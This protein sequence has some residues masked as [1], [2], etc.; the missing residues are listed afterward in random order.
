MVLRLEHVEHVGAEGLRAPHHVGADRIRLPGHGKV[1]RGPFHHHPGLEQ[2]VDELRRRG[3]VGLV[4]WEDVPARIAQ[5]GIEQLLIVLARPAA[6]AEAAHVAGEVRLALPRLQFLAQPVHP[7][8]LD[9]PAVLV[10][11]LDRVHPH[12]PDAV[13]ERLPVAR[14]EV[15]HRLV[16]GHRVVD[17]LPEV[18]R[19]R[20]D[21]RGQIV[22]GQHP[23]EDER[24]LHRGRVPDR[25]REEP[26]HVVEVRHR[27]QAAV[28]PCGVVRSTPP[29]RARLSLRGEARVHGRPHEVDPGDDHG[30]DVVVERIP[31]RRG[32][33]YG[34]RR[35]RLVVVVD[36][37]RI[38]RPVHLPV[39]VLGFRLEGRVE[40]A[41]VVVPHVLLVED[42]DPAGGALRLLLGPRIPVRD[43]VHPVGVRV[44]EE[45][46]DVVEDPHRLVVGPAHE[47]PQRFHQLLRAQDL[48]GVETAIDPHDGLAAL[49]EVT[50]LV[51]RHPSRARQ[52]GRDLPVFIQVRVVL[53]RGDDRHE[54]VA[55]LGRLPDGLQ[56]HARRFGRQRLPVAGEVAVVRK[57]VVGADPVA[58]ERL[59][60]REILRNAGTRRGE[61]QNDR[62]GRQRA[63][64]HG[65][66]GGEKR[67]FVDSPYEDPRQ[68]LCRSCAD[69][70]RTR[71][72]LGYA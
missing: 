47:L 30:V 67:H 56:R 55:A 8:G 68:I 57:L 15:E 12:A 23:L 22:V 32:E 69:P 58:E 2:R 13:Q 60:R 64:G 36:D 5:V 70:V 4:R 10:P 43:E 50:R 3:E 40:I 20:R 29:R 71:C 27:A 53:G 59:R 39:H 62:D 66:V 52:A 33:E 38:P 31:E 16:R 28:P 14:G 21:R 25:L 17:R 11:P 1:G 45:D 26:D 37:L 63:A 7:L 61:G 42:G 54:L 51:F 19:L 35:T 49:R 18:P 24:D 44:D 46:D 48:R 65:P 6:A 9:R 72:R 41:V 34:P